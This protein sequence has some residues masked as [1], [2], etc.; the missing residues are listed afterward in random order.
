LFI[1]Q[2]AG[3]WRL[4]VGGESWPDLARDAAVER[5]QRL[6]AE[7]LKIRTRALTTT[8]FARLCLADLFIHGI[9]GG[10]YDELT[11]DIITRHCG[12]RPSAFLI[13]TGTL[14]LPLQRYF[15][16][17]ED[18][19]AAWR[20][21]RDIHWN[22]QRHLPPDAEDWQDMV[23]A[24]MALARPQ[25]INSPWARFMEMRRLTDR[26]RTRVVAIE[27]DAKKKAV[28]SSFEVAANATLGRRDYAF[29][30]FSESILRPF[31]TQFQER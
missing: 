23:D 30:L 16:T 31:L 27:A 2:V 8:L 25:H 10:K 21:V 26:I 18:E 12:I 24:K 9:G 4:R 13:L 22:P 11:D 17:V 19:R 15:A 20:L 14:Q 6:E 7:G 1:R 5:W 29:C 3:G 28:Q